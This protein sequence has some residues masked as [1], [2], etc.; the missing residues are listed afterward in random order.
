MNRKLDPEGCI[1]FPIW[2]SFSKKKVY[3]RVD[4]LENKCKV[5]LKYVLYNLV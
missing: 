5:Q 3:Q 1:N 2:I 4:S